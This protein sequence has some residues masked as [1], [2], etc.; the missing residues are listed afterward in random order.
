MLTGL[1]LSHQVSQSAKALQWIMDSLKSQGFTAQ[2]AQPPR[3]KI[4]SL[5][6]LIWQLKLKHIVHF[7][8]FCQLS[9]PSQQCQRRQ[10]SP[11]TP[12]LRKKRADSTSTPVSFTTRTAKLPASP[13]LRRRCHGRYFTTQKNL[14]TI[15][16]IFCVWPP[17]PLVVLLQVSFIE[18]DPTGYSEKA[19]DTPDG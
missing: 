6:A 8:L 10:T 19:E 15:L 16:V 2:G 12:V 4:T 5:F 11:A 3:Q 9:F 17:G 7:P 13:C 1:A 18:Y 14:T